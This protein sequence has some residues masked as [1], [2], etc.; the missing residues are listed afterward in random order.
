[1]SKTTVIYKS[2]YG[3]TKTYAQWIAEDLSADLLVS[4]KVKATDLQQY[5]TIIFGGGLYAGSVSGISLLKQ[6]YDS[7]KDKSIYLFTVGASTTTDPLV[8]EAI[9]SALG[10]ILTP[11]MLK[12]I[13]VYHLRGGMVYS[14][15]GFIDKNLMKM[16]IKML[17]KKPPE[18]LSGE[19]KVMMSTYGQD[20]DFTDRT[21]IAPLVKDVKSVS[22]H[23]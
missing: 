14:K 22:A 21:T 2:K 6:N 13:K 16:M 17:N 12:N 3:S 7:I 11:N 19:E 4:D 20:V 10:R 15:M 1:M 18:E 9:R 23:R 8:I 5:D